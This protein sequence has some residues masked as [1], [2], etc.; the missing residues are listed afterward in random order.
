MLQQIG[1]W[2][3]AKLALRKLFFAFY[4]VRFKRCGGFLA[5][6]SFDIT[7]HRY[8]EIGKLTVGD[9]FRL[10]AIHAYFDGATYTPSVTIGDSVSFGT[11]VHLACNHRLV[12]GNHVL[13]GSHIYITDHD[14]GIYAGTAA[15]SRSDQPPA[16]RTL[17][18]G[19]TVVIGN[20]VFI[21]E[22]VNILKN[23][24]IGDGA[25]IAAGA[26]VTRDVPA[27]T[28]VAGNPARV[29]KRHDATRG[30]WLTET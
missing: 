11:D 18:S 4:R 19:G 23:V 5:T 9:R 12:I 26:V 20:N 22:Y 2:A 29:I 28:I 27:G 17:T 15:H 8:I 3:F 21:G 6:G 16:A 25:V 14:H 1:P 30:A 10:D 7:G 24:T 13:G